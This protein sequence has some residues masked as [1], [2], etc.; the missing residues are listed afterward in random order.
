ME[1][2]DTFSILANHHRLEI[3]KILSKQEQSF[4]AMSKALDLKTGHLQ[5]H[6]KALQ[7]AGFIKNNRRRRTYSMTLRGTTALDGIQ[8]LAERLS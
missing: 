4:S 5:F 2:A 6:L 8:G 7:R 3:L 1:I